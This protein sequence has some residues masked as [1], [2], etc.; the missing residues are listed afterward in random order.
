MMATRVLLVLAG[1][2]GF[3]AI[4]WVLLS[5]FAV[6][7]VD[8]GVS[9]HIVDSAG[10]VRGVMFLTVGVVLLLIALAVRPAQ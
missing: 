10:I 6:R 3:L 4:V 2:A 5:A 9:R 8:N 1:V 7:S